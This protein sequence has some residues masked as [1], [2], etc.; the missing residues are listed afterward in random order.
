MKNVLVLTE[1]SLYIWDMII[2]GYTF[3]EICN[4]LHEKFDEDEIKLQKDT[5]DFIE[6]LIEKDYICLG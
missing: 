6:S 2:S 5:N 4:N 1:V 3:E